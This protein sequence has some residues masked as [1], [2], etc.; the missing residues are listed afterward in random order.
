MSEIR[1]SSVSLDLRER[2]KPTWAAAISHPMVRQIGAGTLPHETF[3]GYFEQNI[4]YLEDYARAI[5]LIIGHAPD[6]EALDVLSRFL[7]QIVGTE[8]PANVAFL[9]RL[10]GSPAAISALDTMAPVTYAYT[11]H[12]L[13]TAAQG[14]CAEGLTAV[15]PCQWSYGELA[16]PL[17]TALPG[18]PVYADWVAMFGHGGYSALVAETTGLLDRLA[19]PADAAVMARLSWIFDIS[20]RY[21]VQ[22]WD[23]AYGEPAGDGVPAGDGAP[24]GKEPGR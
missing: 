18:D 17:M 1:S 14:S 5:G 15:L 21:E 12:L 22:F 2:G 11:R 24:P 9:R 10:G 23:M 4:L 8:I 16:T 7:Q 13:Y 6:G 19:D 20:T 3:R